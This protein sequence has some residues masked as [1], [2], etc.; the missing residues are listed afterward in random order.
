MDGR[1]IMV[2]DRRYGLNLSL[3]KIN[4]QYRGKM[5]IVKHFVIF[6]K[7]CVA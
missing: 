5:G 7:R 6:S 2:T 4:D 1:E 3:V